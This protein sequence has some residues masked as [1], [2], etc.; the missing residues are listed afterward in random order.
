MRAKQCDVI[1]E[2]LYRSMTIRFSA[3]GWRK[4]EPEEPVPQ[5]NPKLFEQL[6]YRALGEHCIPESKAA[7]LLGIPMM[8]FYKQRQLETAD[9]APHQ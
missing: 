8:S 6:V 9:D 2:A 3:K 4:L 5:E 7:E 1:T